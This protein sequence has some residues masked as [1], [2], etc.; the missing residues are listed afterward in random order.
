MKNLAREKK[1]DHMSALVFKDGR[2]PNVRIHTYFLCICPL[3]HFIV[4]RIPTTTGILATIHLTLQTLGSI[5]WLANNKIVRKILCSNWSIKCFEVFVV[6]S[7]SY[8]LTSISKRRHFLTWCY[9]TFF[10]KTYL[11]KTIYFNI[12]YFAEKL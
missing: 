4:S 2:A 8:P 6:S 12:F 11:Y 3:Y 7:K 1:E 10:K 5:L 9:L